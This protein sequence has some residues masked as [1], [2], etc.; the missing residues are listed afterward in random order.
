MRSEP[1]P[2]FRIDRQVTLALIFA[3]AVQ[4]AG[5]L[6]WAGRAAERLSQLERRTQS[7]DDVSERLARLEEQNAHIQN[8]LTR[9][10]RQLDQRA[11]RP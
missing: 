7:Q 6:I 5:S 1:L 2:R 8:T 10:E 11:E 4:T 9:I 3:M